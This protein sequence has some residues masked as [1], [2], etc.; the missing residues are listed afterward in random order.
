MDKFNFSSK[1]VAIDKSMAQTLIA[2]SV[3]VFILVFCLIASKAIL[4]NYRY[5]SKVLNAAKDAR[6]KLNDDIT[7]YNGLAQAYVDF[8]NHNP[9]VLGQQVTGN[10]NNNTQVVLNAL[11]A[12]YDYAALT[13]SLY[14]ILS[15]NNLSTDGTVSVDNSQVTNSTSSGSQPVSIPVGFDISSIDVNGARSF[16]QYLSQVTRPISVDSMT[17]SGD[18]SNISLNIQAHTYYQPATSLDITQKAVN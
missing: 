13:T 2:V 3:T 7:A 12:E 15:S 5:Q 6:A 4:T 1:H 10:N 16:L 11:P 14:Y 8:N 18:G 9:N 17:I